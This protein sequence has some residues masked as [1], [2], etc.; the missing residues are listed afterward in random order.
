MKK[1]R[2]IHYCSLTMLESLELRKKWGGDCIPDN[3]YLDRFLK[4]AE[5]YD[6]GHKKGHLLA[7]CYHYKLWVRIKSKTKFFFLYKLPGLLK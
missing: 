5:D 2:K 6:P 7:C 3:N 4:A 1:N